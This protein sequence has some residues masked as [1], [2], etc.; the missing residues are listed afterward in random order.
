[1]DGITRRAPGGKSNKHEGDALATEE[2]LWKDESELA[3]LFDTMT[4]GVALNE[5]VYDDNHEMVDYRVVK[6]NAR[7]YD[8]ADLAA[9]PVEGNLATR[10]YG[11]SR[12]FITQFWREH[13]EKNATAYSELQSPMSN[14]WF[15]IATSPFKD[16]RFVTSFIDITERK[17]IEEALRET[18]E[19]YRFLNETAGVGIAYYAPDGTLLSYNVIAARF[20]RCQP[21]DF[22]GRSLF[23]VL[24]GPEAEAHFARIE[25]ALR[26]AVPLEYVDK[27]E[28]SDGARWLQSTFTVA[29]LAGTEKV[30]QVI[31]TDITALKSAEREVALLKR[32]IDVVAIPAYWFGVDNRLVYVNQAGCAEVGYSQSE[33]VGASLGKL[34]PNVTDQRM[35][36]VWNILRAK[37]A[38]ASE[39][40]HRRK[41]GSEF[42]V[43][44]HSNYFV[45]DGQEYCCVFVTDLTVRRRSE[46]AQRRLEQEANKVHK[47]EALGILAGGI[48]HDFNNLLGAIYGYIDLAAATTTEPETAEC[49]AKALS[50]IERT[51]GLTHQL[52]TFAKGG[53]PVKTVSELAPFLQ[54]ATRFAL[55]GSNVACHFDLPADLWTCD[56]DRN[57]IGQVIDNIVINAV[58]AMPNGGSLQVA[59]ANVTLDKGAHPTLPP[60]RYV[61]ISLTDT[62]VGMPKE[63]LPRIFDPFYTTKP[64][65]HGLGLATSYSIVSRHRGSIDVE[66]EQG[67]G[68][69]FRVYLPAGAHGTSTNR[70]RDANGG[71]AGSGKIFVVDD[72][73]SML[74]VFRSMLVRLGYDV[75]CFSDGA[76]ALDAMEE[77]ASG[78]GRL[79]AVFFDLTIPGGMGGEEAVRLAR[80]KLP[81]LP[82]FVTSGYAASPVMANPMGFG[83]TASISKPFTFRDLTELLARH[84][85]G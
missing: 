67:R 51:R 74:D 10:L 50:S 24:P 5:C 76:T 53:V 63:M 77:L 72:E 8:V 33:L 37:G 16:D 57:Q 7:Y 49:L 68:S 65:G 26:S 14:R 46:Q 54:E 3:I 62:G 64:K 73:A 34:N 83:F 52:L 85:P 38:F 71:H 11:M 82:I 59:A 25:A 44:I 17:R 75:A 35:A 4:E 21:G 48:A 28:L 30:V 81:H 78:D 22:V 58:Q 43:E 1:M 31:A 12:E 47:L 56:Y 79:T 39:S 6:V 32:S 13:K 42:P 40:V 70:N 45:F 61:K 20:M 36:E 55:S 15:Y 27:I 41:D 84:L 19:R 9:T 23:D 60:G 29:R 2:N 69:T 66:S 18:I 80:R